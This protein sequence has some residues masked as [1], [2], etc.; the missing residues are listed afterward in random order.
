[1]HEALSLLGLKWA[2]RDD[3]QL[4]RKAW[5]RKLKSV[6]PDKNTSCSATERTQKLNQA[7]DVL[8]GAEDPLIKVQ[9]ETEEERVAK[10][11]EQAE[12]QKKLDELWEKARQA[13]RER[14]VRNRKKRAEG[15]RIHRRIEDYSE[16]KALIED[17][18]SFFKNNFTSKAEHVSMADI[19]NLFVKSRSNTT[20]LERRLFHRHAK[21]LFA[22]AWPY[23]RY[24]K[25]FNKWSFYGVAPKIQ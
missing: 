9:R 25:H 7:K 2:D 8:L 1:M 14:Y 11:K 17:M 15:S 18:K 6:H 13:Q 21:R 3:P 19:M 23:A 20:D 24:T 4:I 16:G 22:A 12:A 10:E 5:K